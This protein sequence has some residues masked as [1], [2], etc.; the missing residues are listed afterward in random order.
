MTLNILGVKYADYLAILE[1][2]AAIE[3]ITMDD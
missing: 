3:G 1:A 2:R